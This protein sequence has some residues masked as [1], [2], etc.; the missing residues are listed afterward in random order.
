SEIQGQ[1]ICVETAIGTIIASGAQ[2]SVVRGERITLTLRPE[3]LRLQ[4]P[5][6]AISDG[7]NTLRGF[8]AQA[9]FLGAQIEY[10]VRVGVTDRSPAGGAPGEQEI[11][12]RQQNIGTVT[13]RTAADDQSAGFDAGLES[14]WR[15]FGPGEQVTLTW[16]HET[17]L[18]LRAEAQG[19]QPEEHAPAQQP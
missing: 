8:V 1:H 15:A 4:S 17:S 12:V 14:E 13:G 2:P 3:K 5:R 6:A 19:P 16:R 10:R 9:T 18:I 7:W 11:T